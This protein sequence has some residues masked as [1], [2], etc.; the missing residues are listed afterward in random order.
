MA[1]PIYTT[2]RPRIH[3]LCVIKKGEPGEGGD[4]LLAGSASEVY[5][6]LFASGR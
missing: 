5:S 3:T 4:W 6:V 2:P 1:N